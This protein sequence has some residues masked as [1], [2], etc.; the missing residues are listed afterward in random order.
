MLKFLGF[1]WF[2]FHSREA[3]WLQKYYKI[4]LNGATVSQSKF[5]HKTAIAGVANTIL[6]AHGSSVRS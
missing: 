3:S 4:C 5:F 2:I 1:V 6:S